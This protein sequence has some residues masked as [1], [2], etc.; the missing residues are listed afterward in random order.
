[1]PND[2]N[3]IEGCYGEVAQCPFVSSNVKEKKPG[4]K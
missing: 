2:T 4:M 3:R 1:M